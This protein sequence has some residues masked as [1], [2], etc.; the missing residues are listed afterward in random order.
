MRKIKE[1]LDEE[2]HN[3]SINW[4]K[5]ELKIH[6]ALPILEEKYTA[7]TVEGKQVDAK[8]KDALDFSCTNPKTKVKHCYRLFQ[9]RFLNGYLY[10]SGIQIG[11][12]DDSG[13]P[14][15]IEQPQRF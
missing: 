13:K 7:S 10:C 6:T 12:Y 8:W 11:I 5:L 15:L 9:P 2:I 3:G 1:V 14:I 4:E